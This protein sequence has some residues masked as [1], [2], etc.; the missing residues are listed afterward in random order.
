[1]TG[2]LL[3]AVDVSRSYRRGSETVRAVAGVDLGL[4]PGRLA[5]LQGPSGSGKTSLLNLLAGWEPADSGT[6]EWEGVP[7]DPSSLPWSDLAVV[8]QRYGLLPELT[9]M[10]NASLPHRL[11]GGGTAADTL[12]ALDFD[13]ELRN[14]LPEELSHGQR[15]RVAVARATTVSPRVLLVDEPTSAQDEE[16]AHLV[17]AALRA[18]TDAGGSCLVASHDPIAVEYADEVLRMRDGKLA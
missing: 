13:D 7:V 2:P 9:A 4:V 18:A 17:L 15:Q 8:P 3:A 5:V 14:A 1:M 16:S 11:T 12:A 6:I 10:E